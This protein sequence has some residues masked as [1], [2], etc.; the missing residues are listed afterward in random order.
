MKSLV[1]FL[2][3]ICSLLHAD[4]CEK[5]IELLKNEEY[6]KA[7]SY[8]ERA[9]AQEKTEAA[10]F[11]KMICDVALGHYAKIANACQNCEFENKEPEAHPPVTSAEQF[12]SY[13]CRQK[14]RKRAKQM[15]SLVEKLVAKT[16]PGFL[17]KIQTF[18]LLNP[19]IDS[20]ERTG[21]NCCKNGQTTTTCTEPLV[22][23]LELWNSEGLPLKFD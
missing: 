19:Y 23:Q 13:E 16:V 7:A 20:L 11:G 4:N 2:M 17:Q 22:R 8:F 15:R 5:G 6:E 18:R 1:Y 12:A 3:F 10:L 9:A 14:V 21:I